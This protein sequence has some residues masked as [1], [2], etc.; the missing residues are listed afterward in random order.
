MLPPADER[1]ERVAVVALA[2]G[3]EARALRL[4]DLEEILPRE[5]QR[6]LG[7]FGAGGAEIGMREA[8]GFADQ[9]V[10]EFLGGLAD[11]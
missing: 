1:A 7:P 3:D 11:E 6:G 4:A 2:A 9:D 8:A 10:G 5:L